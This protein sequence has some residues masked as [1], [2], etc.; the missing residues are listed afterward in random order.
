MGIHFP[1]LK[2]IAKPVIWVFPE[3]IVCLDCGHTE[4]GVPEAELVELR[5]LAKGNAAGSA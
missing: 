3:L 1:G 4:F 5:R 2:N